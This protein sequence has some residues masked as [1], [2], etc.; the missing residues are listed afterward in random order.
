MAKAKIFLI[1]DN[2]FIR[3]LIKDRLTKEDY[4][5]FVNSD[6]PDILNIISSQAPDLI[7]LDIAMN[8]LDGLDFGDK[9][10]QFPATQNI[11]V[12]MISDKSEYNAI[13]QAIER[14]KAADYLVKPFKPDVLIWKVEAVLEDRSQQEPP[15]GE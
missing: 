15:P 1:A 7:I 11:P 6:T 5:V 2:G 8:E 12:I 13:K 4:D 3:D 14:V 9:L 10:S